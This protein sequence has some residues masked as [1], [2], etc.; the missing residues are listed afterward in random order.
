M[1]NLQLQ[2]YTGKTRQGL[3]RSSSL[4][5]FNT[6]PSRYRPTVS[7]DVLKMQMMEERL[8]HLEKQRNQQNEQINALMSYQMNQNRLGTPNG[9]LLSANNILPPIGYHLSSNIPPIEK[10]YYIMKTDKDAYRKERKLK[11]Y[12]KNIDELKDL[13]E[14]ERDK[15]R[16]HRNIRNNIYLPIRQDIN[17]FMD[18]MNYKLQQKI[19]NDNNIMNANIN[20][21]QNNYDEIKYFLNNKMDKLELKQKMDFENLKNELISNANQKRQQQDLLNE[22]IEKRIDSN[23]NKLSY[24]IEEQIRNQRELDDIKHQKE[25]DELR[26]KHELEEIENRKIMEELKFKNMR[27]SILNQRQRYN[28]IPQIIQQPAPMIQQYPMPFMYPMPMPTY[29]NNTSNS[30]NP[31]DE[32]FKLYMM[33]Q[34]FGEEM[35][36]QKKKRKVKKYNVYYPPPSYYQGK[37]HHHHYSRSISD[38]SNSITTRKKSKKTHSSREFTGSNKQSKKNKKSKKSSKST[39]T[40]KKNKTSKK[41]K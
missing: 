35:F 12:K 38:I 2:Y 27:N 28:P 40:S 32:L 13:L 21:V 15:R 31:S 5:L 37:H 14:K 19:Q 8:K 41:K 23:R 3:T 10:K 39:R 7:P 9:L 18:Q 34:L 11:E 6:H 24:D 20:E 26:H 30:N 25:L 36:P 22:L 17:S 4:P 1:D 33:K 16:F 29:N